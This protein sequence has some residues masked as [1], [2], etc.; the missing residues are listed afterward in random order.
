MTKSE[1]KNKT[2]NQSPR[3]KKRKNP[4][5]PGIAALKFKPTYDW[6]VNTA[7]TLYDGFKHPFNKDQI[8]YSDCISGSGMDQMPTSSVDL[9]IADPPFGIKFTGKENFYN[10]KSEYV[11]NGYG[12]VKE[13]YGE[14][15]EAWIS[16]LPR[17]LKDT[18]CVFIFSGWTNLNDILN[19]VAKTDLVLINHI[20]WKYQF[21]VFT[22][23]KFVSSHYH[24]LFLVKNRKKYFFNKIEHYPEDVWIIP[25][26]FQ[27]GERKNSTKLP[28][29]VVSRCIHFC[30]EPGGL[31]F[32]PFMGNGTSAICAKA[33]YRHYYGFEINSDMKDIIETNL[34][35]T[36]PGQNYKPY[37]T[38]IPDKEELLKKYPAAKKKLIDEKNL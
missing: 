23:R 27:P 22:K 29:E 7:K 30:S 36:I 17:I 8:I 19:A 20:I 15:S 4:Y 38:L 5:I 26:K 13:N 14:F 12:E 16:K 18:S 24:L 25:R 9:I 3:K 35:R 28:E 21:G 2:K 10:R 11:A 1:I 33:N 31:I 34:G 32:D 37:R 6:D